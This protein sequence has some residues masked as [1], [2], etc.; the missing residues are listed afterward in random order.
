ME[1]NNVI[2]LDIDGVLATHKQFMSNRKKF[3]DK[4]EDAKELNIPYPFDQKCVKIFN[5]ILKETDA[6]I[7]L[8]S[9]WRLFW[10]LEELDRIFKFNKII[11]SPIAITSKTKLVSRS[12]LELNRT[13]QIED[14]LDENTVLNYV[15]VDDL[16]LDLY[17]TEKFVKTK[18]LQGL[19]ESNIKEKIIKELIK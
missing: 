16:H 10:K 6:D 19:K 13:K 8:T 5:E 11:K 18:D 14:F 1:L 4:H 2:F 12:N 9:D 3:Q 17:L 7:V 15:V